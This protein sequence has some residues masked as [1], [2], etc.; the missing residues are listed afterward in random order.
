MKKIKKIFL[1]NLPN[2]NNRIS[3]E[4]STNKKVHFI[5]D[6]TEGDLDIVDYIKGDPPRL[7]IKYNNNYSII[8]ASEFKLCKIGRIIG[9]ITK[10]FRVKIGQTLK[11]NKRDLTITNREYRQKERIDEKNRKSIINQKWCKY[12]CN[13]CGYK[14]WIAEADLVAKGIGCVC[15]ANQL[16]VKGINDIATTH[17]HLTKYF[18]DIEDTYKYTKSSGKVVLMKCP[19]CGYEKEM[20]LNTLYTSYF[21]CKKCNDSV[22]YPEKLMF[23]FLKTLGNKFIYQLS[24]K[25][26]NWIN[27]YKYDFYF[28]YNNEEYIIETHGK[29]HYEETK[30]SKWDK[31]EEIQENDRLKKKLA[32]ENGIKYENYIIID[33]RESELNLI[34]QNILNSKL[35]ELFNLN[36]IN[37]AECGEYACSNLMKSI[38]NYWKIHNEINNENLTTINLSN[39]FGLHSGTISNYLK[40]GNKLK[41]CN[42]NPIKENEKARKKGS[43]SQSKKIEIFKDNISLGMFNSIAKLCNKSEELY[44]I[45]ILHCGINWS[46]NN[47]KLYKGFSFKYIA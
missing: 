11:D 37:W 1:E 14:G 35:N 43:L 23:I 9:K 29:Q 24:K 4:N 30:G 27:K 36:K 42:Y 21:R 3:W 32:L 39:I 17:P 25:N 46:I 22:T 10:D 28:E 18:A 40:K 19:D 13:K 15:C 33:C 2:T 8:G 41:W 6:D 5:Y 45:K 34:K 31:L 47:N 20:K 26:F 12:H 7:K 38:C 16:V 44:G